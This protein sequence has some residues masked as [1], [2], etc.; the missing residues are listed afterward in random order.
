[1]LLLMG[2]LA[3]ASLP[4]F[5]LLDVSGRVEACRKGPALISCCCCGYRGPCPASGPPPGNEQPR[6]WAGGVAGFSIPNSIP[7]ELALSPCRLAGPV[8]PSRARNLSG[9]RC[10]AAQKTQFLEIAHA[11]LISHEF[12]SFRE[13]D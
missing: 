1:M 5:G 13:C 12:G 7:A 8:P 10:L 3:G 9:S 6:V 4:R 11:D 2:C